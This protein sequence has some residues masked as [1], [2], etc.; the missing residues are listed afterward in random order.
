MSRGPRRR[1]ANQAVSAACRLLP[2][3]LEGW[4]WAM[5]HEVEAIDDDGAALG[6][7]LDGLRGAVSQALAFHLTGGS[8]DMSLLQALRRPPVVGLA[9]AIGATGLGLAHLTMAGAPARYLAVNAGALVIG[10]LVY[11]AL[12]RAPRLPGTV[13]LVMGGL[14]FATALFGHAPEGAARWLMIGPLF[15]QP[16]LI[17]LPMMIVGFARTRTALATAGMVAAAL[18]LALQ[19]DRAMAG[20][21]VAG[22]AGLAAFRRDHATV[23]A[24]AA[25]GAGFAATLFQPDTL[26]AVAHVDQI[27]YRA[28]DI[29]LLAGLAVVGGSALLVVPSFV[30]SREVG[31]REAR[32]AFG[33]LWL[34]TIAAA[35]LGNY[36]TPVVG[37]GGSAVIGYLLSLAPL[38]RQREGAAAVVEPAAA[39]PVD[40]VHR[41][42]LPTGLYSAG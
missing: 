7:A 34:A 22:L 6:F 12:A 3:P 29:D 42:D 26:P 23:A 14:L 27:L 13:M 40:P 32:V 36:P 1:L 35:A 18:A 24:L 33:A 31:Q 38:P 15:I 21:L 39:R 41:T 4:G 30:G 37:Y 11:S 28:F 16:S 20:V 25:A 8:T 5:R 19:P 17:L 10:L 9:C 2:A